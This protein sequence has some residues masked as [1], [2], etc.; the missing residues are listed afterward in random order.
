MVRKRTGYKKAKKKR[1]NGGIYWGVSG[2]MKRKKIE[3]EV[4]GE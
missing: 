1:Q 2:K 4:I 3:R